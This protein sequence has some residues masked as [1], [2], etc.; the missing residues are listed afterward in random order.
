M[1]VAEVLQETRLARCFWKGAEASIASR[2]PVSHA[3]AACEA[4]AEQIEHK[5]GHFF[6]FCSQQPDL[7]KAGAVMESEM[8]QHNPTRNSATG[9]L[10]GH[11]R[12]IRGFGWLG[13][14]G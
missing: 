10:R 3:E 2:W 4:G 1:S 9:E 5:L 12:L 11:V 13:A 14:R 7:Q 6:C 8:L